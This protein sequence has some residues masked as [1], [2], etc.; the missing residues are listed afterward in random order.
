M[1]NISTCAIEIEPLLSKINQLFDVVAEGFANAH[2]EAV[3]DRS[4]NIP[5]AI[6]GMLLPV[7][8]VL[9]GHFHLADLKAMVRA[10]RDGVV[11]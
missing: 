1:T 6:V 2:H 5:P 8:I 3:V 10:V 4:I 9:G 11:I 7:A